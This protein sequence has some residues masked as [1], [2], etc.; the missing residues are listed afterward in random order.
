MLLEAEWRDIDQKVTPFKW[1]VSSLK[2]LEGWS[3]RIGLEQEWYFQDFLDGKYDLFA[4][5]F[6]LTLL[7]DSKIGCLTI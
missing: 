2:E 1:G 6:G 3:P 5:L 4:N 7:P